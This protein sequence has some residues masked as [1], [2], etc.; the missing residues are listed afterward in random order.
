MQGFGSP[1]P[2]NQPQRPG[3]GRP[4]SE[5]AATRNVVSSGNPDACSATCC[6]CRAVAR[7]TW[8]RSSPGP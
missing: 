6:T 3:R 1:P 2:T 7:R 8:L 4:D 5:S